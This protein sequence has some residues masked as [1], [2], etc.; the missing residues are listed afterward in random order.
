MLKTGLKFVIAV[1]L[2]FGLVVAAGCKENVPYKYK[3]GDILCADNV[4]LK[5]IVT[6]RKT[7][8]GVINDYTGYT[9]SG[10]QVTIEE[11]FLTL[12]KNN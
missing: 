8:D 6:G 9:K 10:K 3:K 11:E 7:W 2:I 1:S 5:F 12:C 4:G